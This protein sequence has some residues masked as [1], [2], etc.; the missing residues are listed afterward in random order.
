MG[1]LIAF[2]IGSC[3]VF[4]LLTLADNK[5]WLPSRKNRS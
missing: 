2:V 4:L 1:S 3:L 5:G